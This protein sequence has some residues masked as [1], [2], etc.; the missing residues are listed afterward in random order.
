MTGGLRKTSLYL[1]AG[2]GVIG[3]LASAAP[4][5]HAEY[6]TREE[7]EAYKKEQPEIKWKGAPQIVSE[8]GK[9]KFKVRGR[10]MVDYDSIDQDFKITGDDDV[11]AVELRRARLGVEGVIYYNFKYKFEVDFAGDETEIKDAYIAYAN[12][13]D[14]ET[15][16]IIVGNFKTANSLEQMTSSRFL[17]FLERAAFVDAFVLDRA[18]GGGVWAGDEHWS[19]QAGYYGAEAG[20]QEGYWTDPTIATVRGTVTPINNDTTV[21]H[22]GASYR[23]RNAGTDRDGMADLFRYRARPD[24]HLAD[25]FIQTPNRIIS[26]GDTLPGFGE[27]DNLWLVEGAFVWRRFTVQGEYADMS[28]DIAQSIANASPNYKGWYVQGSIFLTDDMRNFEADTAEFGRIKPNNPFFSEKGMFSGTGAWEL[29]GRYDV[30]ELGDAATA[31]TNST[32]VNAMD[33][34]DCGDQKAWTIGLNWW[35]TDYAALKFNYVNAHISGGDNNGA[36]VQ[37]FAMRAQIDW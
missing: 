17:M 14:W 29:A 3:I 30:L 6:V 16:E 21:L 24:L 19:F 23:N 18:I 28:V 31:I 34:A 25:R 9:F 15:S 22:M 26:T 8:D 12:W 37:G 32:A 4:A 11:S 36:D 33:C 27:T 35:M 7:F 20:T 13:A 10:L 2:A 5:A 1:I